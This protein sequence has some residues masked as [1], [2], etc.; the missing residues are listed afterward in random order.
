VVK[1]YDTLPQY[2]G[3][4]IVPGYLATAVDFTN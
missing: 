1:P 3:F 2:E 4:N